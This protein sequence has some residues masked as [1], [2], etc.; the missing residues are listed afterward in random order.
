MAEHDLLGRVAA[1]LREWRVRRGI[2]REQLAVRAEVDPQMIK[3]IENGRANPALVVLSRLASALAI[4]LSLMLTSEAAAAPLPTDSA[5]ESEPFDAINVGE[6]IRSLRKHRHLSR[7]GLARMVDVRPLTLSR[8]ETGETDTRVLVL[9]PLARAL[10]VDA[11]EFV[12]AVEVR[13]RTAERS[14]DGWH[15]SAEGVLSRRISHG[16][17]SQLWEWR[18]APEVRYVDDPPADVVEEIATAIRGDI[19]V[20]I[21][22]VVHHLRRGASLTLPVDRPRTFGNAGRSTARLL[23]FQVLK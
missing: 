8:Y 16:E 5:V 21:G 15:A 10:G 14:G 2:T 13:R 6:T 1:H 11:D 7:R 18:L 3:R 19:T 17:R 20:T 23:C 9:E 22:E 4:S 12:R